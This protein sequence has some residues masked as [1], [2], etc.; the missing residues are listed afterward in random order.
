MIS[1]HFQINASW[2]ESIEIE[3]LEIALPQLDDRSLLRRFPFD[4]GINQGVGR[5][6]GRLAGRDFTLKNQ[7]GT[8][9]GRGVLFGEGK[10]SLL[11]TSTSDKTSNPGFMAAKS[12]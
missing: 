8:V 4:G 1:G 6:V 2:T 12:F 5:S 10:L 7:A 3:G 11:A 9:N